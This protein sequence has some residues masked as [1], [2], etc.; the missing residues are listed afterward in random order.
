MWHLEALELARGGRLQEARRASAV[1]V[2]IATQ[3]GQRE[4]AA[5]FEAAT[6]VWEAFYGNRAAGREKATQAL[7]LAR[8]RDA[9]YAAAFALTLSGD[10]ARPRALADDLARD[11]PE[12]TS[13]QYMY[14][15]TLRALLSL[16]DHRASAAIQSLEHRLRFDLAPGGIGFN[17]VLRGTLPDLRSRA[18]VP[19]RASARCC[20]RRIPEDSRSSQHRPRGSDGRNGAPAPGKSARALG[21]YD[22]GETRLRRSL[23]T[24]EERRPKIPTVEE[25]RA[26]YARLP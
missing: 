19:R 18:G 10:V 22:K 5:L 7:G 12:D 24:L 2:G 17:G 3:R 9:D 15:P 23:C 13:V 11:F 26:E 25:A 16:N 21:R 1:A 14:L 4:R 8:G 6:A 20:S